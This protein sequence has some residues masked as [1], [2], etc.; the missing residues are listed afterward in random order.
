MRIMRKISANILFSVLAESGQVFFSFFLGVLTARYMGA[1]GKGKFWLVYTVAGLLSLILSMRF[2]RALTYHLSKNKDM[3]GETILY[4]LMLCIITVSII[5][6]ITTLFSGLLYET[7]LKDVRIHWAI[8]VLISLSYY[9]WLL[10]IGV[11]EGLFLFK[12]KAIFLGGTHMLKCILVF[13]ALGPFQMNFEELILFV[14]S[15]ET[16]VFSCIVFYFLGKAKHFL[17]NLSEFL[18][19]LK[20]SAQSFL[21][22]VSDLGVFRVDVFFVNYFSGPAQ[23]GIYTVAISLASI[24]LYGPTAVRNVLLPYIAS[25]PDREITSK[26]SKLLIIVISLL[27]FMLIP[28]VWLGVPPIYGEEFTFS[29]V[30]FMVLLPGAIFWGIFSLLSSDIEG[31]G[32][33]WRVSNISVVSALVAIALNLILIPIWN[34]L[35]AAAVSSI[36]CGMSMILAAR[37]YKQMIG[38][39]MRQLFVPQ[40]EDIDDFF[41]T[42]NHFIGNMK[43]RL[44]AGWCA[45]KPGI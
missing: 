6:M 35:G 23:V 44:S 13:L 38:I 42:I 14:G 1:A 27:S 11:I 36:T 33:P 5:A 20:Y 25:Y 3:L 7:V 30:L 16:I 37:F 45:K 18:R 26:L 24:L 19:I 2:H 17:I 29:R 34:S 10:I 28:L 32:L 40:A 15:V 22:M 8:L 9:L 21:G 31:R 4:G 12:A 43:G 39:K 41:R